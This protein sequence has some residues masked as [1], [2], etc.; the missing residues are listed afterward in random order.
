MSE[1]PPVDVW[2]GVHVQLSQA[3]L[4]SISQNVRAASLTFEGGQWMIR[5]VLADE[6]DE[7]FEE[8]SEALSDFEAMDSSAAPYRF[9]VLVSQEKI[10]IPAPPGRLVFMRRE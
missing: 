6:C 3:L 9:E 4:G 7:D 1:Y 5:F 2:N 8:L 10:E